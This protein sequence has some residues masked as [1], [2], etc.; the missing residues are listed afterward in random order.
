MNEI[1]LKEENWHWCDVCDCVSYSYGCDCHGS[2]CNGCGCDKCEPI[3]DVV[4]KAI[5]NGNHPSEEVLKREVI[6]NYKEY[7]L[8]NGY[9]TNEQIFFCEELMQP[10]SELMIIAMSEISSSYGK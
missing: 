9:K 1:T 5:R 2:A 4:S 7:Y 6:D 8:K 3:W 10:P